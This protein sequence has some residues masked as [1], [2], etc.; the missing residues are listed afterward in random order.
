MFRSHLLWSEKG[1]GILPLR[2][3]LAHHPP[4]FG[5]G[6]GV[7]LAI[8]W[9]KDENSDVLEWLDKNSLFVFFK[10]VKSNV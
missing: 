8:A 3:E 9:S 5:G 2:D 1:A 10:I 4:D 6:R 7:V